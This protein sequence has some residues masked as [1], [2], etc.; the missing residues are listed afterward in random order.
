MPVS[1]VTTVFT[2]QTHTVLQAV[3]YVECGNF[4]PTANLNSNLNL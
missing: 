4:N 2:K 3:Q 1:I